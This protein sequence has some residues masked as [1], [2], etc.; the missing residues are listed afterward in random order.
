VNDTRKH[1][2]RAPIRWEDALA[3]IARA[4]SEDMAARGYFSHTG[5]D[6]SD[7]AVRYRRASFRCAV[8]RADGWTV[9]GGENIFSGN[10]AT[11]WIVDAEGR[12]TPE[13]LYTTEELAT[14][15]V[16]QWRHSPGHLENLLAPHW[17]REGVGVAVTPAG[18][19]LVTQNFC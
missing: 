3:R 14:F 2:G 5:L 4:H 19:V 10:L 11:G 17:E 16:D 12:R 15:I 6:G 18:D 8:T 13:H 1:N 9:E 7:F